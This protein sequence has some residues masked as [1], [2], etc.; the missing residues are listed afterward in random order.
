MAGNK[1]KLD[2]TKG[3]ETGYDEHEN[4]KFRF[5]ENVRVHFSFFCA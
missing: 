4:A 5:R 2:V 1:I 3:T